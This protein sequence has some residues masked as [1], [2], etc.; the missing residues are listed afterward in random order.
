[1]RTRAL[2]GPGVGACILFTCMASCVAPRFHIPPHK[3]RWIVALLCG[4]AFF[5]YATQATRFIWSSYD[6]SQSMPGVLWINLTF[7][8]SIMCGISSGIWQGCAEGAVRKADPGRFPPTP[9]DFA[10]EAWKQEREQQRLARE[11]GDEPQPPSERMQRRMSCACATVAAAAAMPAPRISIAAAA[12]AKRASCAASKRESL[13]GRNSSAQLEATPEPF[14]PS[15]LRYAQINEEIDEEIG[16]G[17]GEGMD[18]AAASAH[19]VVGE[20]SPHDPPVKRVS[21]A[22]G[23]AGGRVG[24]GVS[25]N[26][27]RNSLIR[28]QV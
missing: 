6:D 15:T 10:L 24:R 4:N 20:A 2:L 5:Q 11:A 28:H 9:V 8:L 23:G 17:S 13:V 18:G 22:V 21:T 1:M 16:E 14:L 27:P 3:R 7:V 26:N 12:P 25:V 19:P